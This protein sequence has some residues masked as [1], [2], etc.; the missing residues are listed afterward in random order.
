MMERL[1]TT[2][3]SSRTFHSDN[4]P[5]ILISSDFYCTEYIRTGREVQLKPHRIIV[6]VCSESARTENY[7]ENGGDSART[8]GKNTKRSST[9]NAVKDK[10]I[11][12][13]SLGI[14]KIYLFPPHPKKPFTKPDIPFLS[15]ACSFSSSDASKFSSRPCALISSKSSMLPPIVPPLIL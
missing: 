7:V 10:T 11:L 8:C 9:T 14:T 6:E 3:S 2:N 13:H 1:S 12:Q 4:Y 15:G 5:S